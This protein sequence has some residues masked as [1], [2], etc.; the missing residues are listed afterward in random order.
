LALKSTD[1]A[2]L[3][4][5]YTAL[6]TVNTAI[7]L[8]ALQ[9]SSRHLQQPNQQHCNTRVSTSTTIRQSGQSILQQAKTTLTW[10]SSSHLRRPAPA[11]GKQVTPILV[12]LSVTLTCTSASNTPSIPRLTLNQSQ[13][14]RQKSQGSPHFIRP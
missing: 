9:Q 7:Q 5:T 8:T 14:V 3:D 2:I 1:T 4:S 11:L 13:P 6:K 10:T 12:R